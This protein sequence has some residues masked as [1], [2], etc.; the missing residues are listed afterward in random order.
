MTFQF[1]PVEEQKNSLRFV[2]SEQAPGGMTIYPK[3][4]QP[5]TASPELQGA[6]ETLDLLTEPGSLDGDEG[7]EEIRQRSSARVA[8][9]RFFEGWSD[10]LLASPAAALD[11]ATYPLRRSPFMESEA[12]SPTPLKAFPRMKTSDL[13]G[14]VG[15]LFGGPSAQDIERTGQITAEEHPGAT[16]LGEGLSD[17]ASL[18]TAKAP[19]SKGAAIRAETREAKIARAEREGKKLYSPARPDEAL[20]SFG[21]SKSMQK[22]RRWASRTGEAAGEG[23]FLGMVKEDA[24]PFELAAWTAGANGALGIV[25]GVAGK[26]S[27]MFGPILREADWPVKFAAEVA[28]MSTIFLGVDSLLPGPDDLKDYE[29]EQAAIDKG[30]AL[31]AAGAVAGLV[32]GRAR[33]NRFAALPGST[34]PAIVDAVTSLPRHALTSAIAAWR[35]KPPEERE[36]LRETLQ[37]LQDGAIKVSKEARDKMRK[38]GSSLID[39]LEELQ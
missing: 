18:M 5:Y 3:G 15:S 10:A 35:Q 22:F 38:G 4:G 6:L 20:A 2:P 11:L 16:A 27:A 14:M 34:P 17:I 1:V 26:G 8:R 30:V 33:S 9:D 24:D 23:L 7:R 19:L 32:A 25:K 12:A 39:A 13:A 28:V 31:A 21:K 37:G 29:A 36:R